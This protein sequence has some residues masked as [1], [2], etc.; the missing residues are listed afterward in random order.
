[1]E[2]NVRKNLIFFIVMVV[3]IALSAFMADLI[4]S[5]FGDVEVSIV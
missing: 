4:E 2:V 3:V 5:D 1:M